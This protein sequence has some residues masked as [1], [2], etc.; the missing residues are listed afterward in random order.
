MVYFDTSMKRSFEHSVTGRSFPTDPNGHDLAVRS[1]PRFRMSVH[2]TLASSGSSRILYS[3]W[4]EEMEFLVV[5]RGQA[6]FRLG[7]EDFTI[8]ERDIVVIQPNMFHSV[9]MIDKFP[10]ELYSVLVHYNFLAGPEIDDIQ[11]KYI[12]P[13]FFGHIV[14]PVHI[15]ADMDNRYGL[16]N[17][18]MTI[19]KSHRKKEKG[20]ELFI[21]S[22]IYEAFYIFSKYTAF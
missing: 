17:V 11:Q 7:Q 14:Y 5:A 9:D 12:L 16:L 3:H 13:F 10:C 18:L 15:E 20:Y 21:K 2:Y 22:K 8:R 19:I 6:R 4:H 1:T